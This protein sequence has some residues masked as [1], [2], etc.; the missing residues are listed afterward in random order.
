[1]KKRV[2]LSLILT[3]LVFILIS[4]NKHSSVEPLRVAL[5][6]WNGYAPL[7]VAEH[8]KT[9]PKNLRIIDYTSNYDIVEDI[10]A[11]RIEAAFLTLDEVLALKKEGIKIKIIYAIDTSNGADAVLAK[12]SIQN[13]KDLKNKRVAY[14]PQSVQEYLLF[15]AL[16]K[17]AMQ[18]S[19]IKSVLCKYDEQID[20]I[21]ED[22]FDAAV[23]FE[24]VKSKLLQ[25]GLHT[26]FSSRDIP[27][28]IVDLLV[29]TEKALQE[30]K[31]TLA[32]TV[33]ALTTAT[34]KIKEDTA[35]DTVAA[36]YLHVTPRTV[37]SVYQDI[38]LLTKE[39]NL[40]LLGGKKPA[41]LYAVKH[42]DDY[43]ALSDAD[44]A[45]KDLIDATLLKE[46]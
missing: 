20:L 39:A 13:I 42:I 43:H 37:R 7:Y 38:K 12:K 31:K 17:N 25:N 41:L 9:L 45:S 5:V 19:D 14:E 24:P 40:Q 6:Q 30:N 21:K 10:K 2:S 35:T 1:M 23:T 22:A 46:K 11:G 44:T 3:A 8:D 28:E 33:Q 15:R 16:K 36:E 32:K 29:V 34:K 26:I 4:C 27:N 18:M